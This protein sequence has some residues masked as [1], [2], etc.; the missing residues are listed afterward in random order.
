[1]VAAWLISAVRSE[2]ALPLQAAARSSR[3]WPMAAT[4]SAFVCRTKVLMVEISVALPLRMSGTLV[5]ARETH[6]GCALLA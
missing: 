6:G 3:S 4:D 5:P 1:M 2:T